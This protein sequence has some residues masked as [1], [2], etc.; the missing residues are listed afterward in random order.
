MPYLYGIDS[1]QLA[2]AQVITSAQLAEI[3]FHICRIGTRG[4]GDMGSTAWYS[5]SFSI[6]AYC[7]ANIQATQAAG[8]PMG[9]YV[10]SYAWDAT[11][12]AREAKD[13]CD[14]LDSW[15]I[16]LELPIFLDWES[17]GTPPGT[18]SY[19]KYQQYIGSTI[20]T[21][22]LQS[23]FVSFHQTVVSRGRRAG[24]YFNGWFVDYLLPS[25]WINSQRAG[26]NYFW[27]AQWVNTPD[28]PHDCDVWQYAG[29]KLAIGNLPT[30][31]Y[32]DWN[33]IINPN[34]INGGGGGSG[35]I[36]IWLKIKKIKGSEN[37][38]RHSILL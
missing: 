21:A 19:E 20:S 22:T 23:I 34:V 2:A 38:G 33:Y 15:G 17:T 30:S 28:P 25:S 27:L 4:Y 14:V 10:F 13:V 9:V 29:D 26:G 31:F 35:A 8:K 5:R 37:N 16:S 18:G 36:P 3:D 7:R 11:S 32:V 1:Y 12:A 6:D 24:M